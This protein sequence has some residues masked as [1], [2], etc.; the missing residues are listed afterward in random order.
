MVYKLFHYSDPIYVYSSDLWKISTDSFHFFNESVLKNYVIENIKNEKSNISDLRSM[1]SH[2]KMN[3]FSSEQREFSQEINVFFDHVIASAD[4][5]QVIDPHG[6]MVS[7][8]F[9]K[10][11]CH[12]DYST[13]MREDLAEFFQSNPLSPEILIQVLQDIFPEFSGELKGK[14][15]VFHG[16]LE[17]SP[18]F[19]TCLRLLEEIGVEI[20]FCVFYMEDNSEGSMAV[21]K[22]FQHFLLEFE[23]VNKLDQDELVKS[24]N[25]K[26]KTHNSREN[27]SEISINTLKIDYFQQH[28]IWLLRFLKA[29]FELWDV[30]K[31]SFKF[32]SAPLKSCIQSCPFYHG[33]RGKLLSTYLKLEVLLDD[34]SD[35]DHFKNKIHGEFRSQLVNIQ[36]QDDSLFSRI[37][38]F[39]QIT[40]EEFD[41]FCEFI[42]DL[43]QF[44]RILFKIIPNIQLIGELLQE[45]SIAYH[46]K[47]FISFL[48]EENKILHLLRADIELIENPSEIKS[49]YFESF[50]SQIYE[51]LEN[52]ESHFYSLLD[53]QGDMREY[54][55]FH[56]L[57][58]GYLR[59]IY[60]ENEFLENL[61]KDTVFYD[62]LSF[63]IQNWK[64]LQHYQNNF[65][66]AIL[67]SQ[68]NIQNL[69]LKLEQKK[70][71]QVDYD[72]MEMMYLFLC[73]E[74]YMKS[75]ILQSETILDHVASYKKFYE[76]LLIY[77]V[78]SQSESMTE[79]EVE[80]QLQQA[81]EHYHDYFPF[82]DEKERFDVLIRAKNYFLQSILKS[83]T[84]IRAFAPSHMEMKFRFG[85]AFFQNSYRTTPLSAFRPFV[86]NSNYSLHKIPKSEDKVDL[87]PLRSELVAYLNRNDTI[88]SSGSWCEYCEHEKNC[89]K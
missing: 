22:L 7:Y 29:L 8:F 20:V 6:N 9:H 18:L 31:N 64:S 51:D 3:G 69:T 70:V 1:L 77:M 62:L 14:T 68:I 55:N 56:A 16:F 25:S 33:S 54:L 81:D 45:L 53:N 65:S 67:C 47:D 50:S 28:D 49:S 2:Q 15:L 57:V 87:F 46:E 75:C 43:E 74:R 82:L 4:K 60:G 72:R 37:S 48:L 24:K 32:L 59:Q 42:E 73:P 19:L 17:L 11:L 44:S 79:A 39:S 76:N 85:E 88:K 10:S 13:Y 52:N 26:R 80:Q 36:N 63:S 23:V 84:E 30:D 5:E 89:K 40:T 78:W 58:T 12:S 38:Y 86:K 35:Y 83:N 41:I 66:A 34:I 27:M 21:Q 61:S 71:V